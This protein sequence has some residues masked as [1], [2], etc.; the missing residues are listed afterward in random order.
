MHKYEQCISV[1]MKVTFPRE[2]AGG[3]SRVATTQE[4]N[5]TCIGMLRPSMFQQEVSIVLSADT[6]V[7]VWTPWETTNIGTTE[8][9]SDWLTKINHMQENF[10]FQQ[11]GQRWWVNWRSWEMGTTSALCAITPPTGKQHDQAHIDQAHWLK[12]TSCQDLDIKLSWVAHLCEDIG[13][14]IKKSC[15]T[16]LKWPMQYNWMNSVQR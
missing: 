10:P 11:Y 3:A 1:K 16:L 5:R 12:C 4:P 8:M 2:G 7:Q 14:K 6:T 13:V 15:W 9:G